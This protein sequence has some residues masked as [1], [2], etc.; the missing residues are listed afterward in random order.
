MSA[1]RTIHIPSLDG[2]RGLAALIVYLSHATRPDL[3]PGG[4]GVTV[5]FFLSG[6]LITTLLR[7]EHEQTGGISFKRFY[8]R[9][10]YRILPPIY[11]VL[12]LVMALAFAGA[13]DHQMQW[14]AVL[15]Q[16]TQLT[17]YYLISAGDS[18]FVPDTAVTWSLS[19]EEHF[20]L[21]FPIALVLLLRRFNRT[22]IATLLFAV[23]ALD[24]AWRWYVFVVLGWGEDYTYRATDT[25]LDSILYGC[26]LGLWCNPALD[27][28]RVALG[29]A[30]ACLIIVAGVTALMIGFMY[31]SEVFRETLRYSLQ[32]VALFGLFFCAVRF[33]Q[34]P[35]FSWLESRPMRALGLISYTF[36]LSHSPILSLLRHHT[37][38]GTPARAV[39]GFVATTA[40]S[41]LMYLLIERHLGTLRRRLHGGPRARAV[42][43]DAP[44]AQPA[45]LAQP[46]S[47]AQPA[48]IVQPA[49]IA[50]PTG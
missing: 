49:G 9:R 46:A 31:R 6:Y 45:G 32:G 43:G 30:A 27:A 33:H 21:L 16:V 47:V 34:W 39:A 22:R 48:G 15:A 11:I 35:L 19:V 13:L 2:I 1:E 40:F 3:I 42:A 5:F 44:L 10:V 29:R 23:C 37:A 36:Y 12:A 7:M 20:Y 24:L 14:D 18:H 28:R 50:Q 38:L 17:N 41:G 26:I 25:R 4:F 8:L